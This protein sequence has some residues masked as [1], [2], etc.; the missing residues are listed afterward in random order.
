M[1]ESNNKNFVLKLVILVVVLGLVSGVAGEAIFSSIYSGGTNLPV[2]GDINYSNSDGSNLIIREAKKVV[3][4]QNEK[5]IETA[6]N[7]SKNIVAIKAKDSANKEIN[8]FYNLKKVDG[9]GLI[10]TNDGWIITNFSLINE[11][12]DSFEKFNVITKDKKIYDI[13]KVVTDKLTKFYFIHIKAVELPVSKFIDQKGISN[14]QLVLSVD[15]QGSN[16]LTSIVNE[17]K[18]PELINSS[19]IFNEHMVLLNNLDPSYRGPAV[20]NLAGEVV[21]LINEDGKIE[22]SY[23]FDA[24]IA[25]LLKNK[26]VKRASLGVNYANLSDLVKLAEKNSQNIESKGVLLVK[27]EKSPAVAKGSAAEAAGL[28][29]GDIILSVNNLELDETMNLTDAIQHFTAGDKVDI[30]Y[31]RKGELKEIQIKLNEIK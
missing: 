19:D 29:E 8:G 16:M 7:S 13:D 2:Y 18:S 20:F 25:G 23:H 10:V 3:V 31:L 30:D 12:P 28:R 15:W 17:K 26:A 27:N 5:V 4:E 11:K 24:A 6:K 14:G 9:Q 1:A 22:P 21:G